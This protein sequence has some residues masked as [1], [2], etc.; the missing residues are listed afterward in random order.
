M[1]A[2]SQQVQQST[3]ASFLESA[4]F[5]EHI[6]RRLQAGLLDPNV[7]HFVQGT[8]ARFVVSVFCLLLFSA[9]NLFQRHMT[10]NPASYKIPE[11]VQLHFMHSKSFSSA[12]GSVLSN[13]RGEMKRKVIKLFLSYSRQRYS[14]FVVSEVDYRQ[15][16]YIYALS[17][18]G[19]SWVSAFRGSRKHDLICGT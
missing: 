12:V 2:V 4:E 19:D 15:A 6:T 1:S 8:T 5:K 3:V 9:D 17:K 10:E 7:L 16:R 18:A 14:Q 13:K 11:A